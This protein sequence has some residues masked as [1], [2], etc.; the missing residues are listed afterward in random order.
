MK[1]SVQLVAAY[2]DKKTDFDDILKTFS[3]D[4]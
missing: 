3:S 2:N 4:T 1:L